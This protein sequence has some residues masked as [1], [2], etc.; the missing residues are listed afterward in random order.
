MNNG[1]SDDFFKS[2]ENLFVK[3]FRVVIL[4]AMTIALV[5]TLVAAALGAMKMLSAEKEPVPAAPAP[6]KGVDIDDFLKSLAPSTPEKISPDPDAEGEKPEV[7]KVEAIKYMTEATKIYEC[8]A[9]LTAKVGAQTE[10]GPEEVRRT[11]EYLR[12]EVQRLA[13]IKS[14]DSEWVTS[15]AEFVCS[16]TQNDKVVAL[17]KKGQ[18]IMTPAINFHIRTWDR[19]NEEREAHEAKEERR[20]TQ[21]RIKEQM[22]VAEDKAFGLTALMVAASAF[23][24]FMVIALYLIFAKIEAN[25]AF[26]QRAIEGAINQKSNVG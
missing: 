25:L 26:I 3:I 12:S 4:I 16:V 14:R 24:A 6:K 17:A 5:V 7:K 13:A 11:V 21:E 20:I 9:A 19:L 18:K 1:K 10:A 23:A 22:R 15:L 8:G 2:I